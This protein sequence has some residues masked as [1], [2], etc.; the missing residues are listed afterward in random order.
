[1]SEGKRE[2][3]RCRFDGR[4]IEVRGG[5]VSKEPEDSSLTTTLEYRW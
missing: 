2:K 1:M 5:R 3:V 4:V